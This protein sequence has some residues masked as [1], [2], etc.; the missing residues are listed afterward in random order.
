MLK[1]S[2]CTEV[3]GVAAV[4][5]EDIDVIRSRFELLMGARLRRKANIEKAVKIQ[6]RIRE[7]AGDWQASKQIRKWRDSR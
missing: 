2:M 3:S 4:A 5:K 1:N 7:K 6:N